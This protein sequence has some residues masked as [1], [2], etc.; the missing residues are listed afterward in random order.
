VSS[1]AFYQRLAAISDALSVGG[2]FVDLPTLLPASMVLELAGEGLRPRL[3]FATAP[4]GS[5]LCL[6][7]DLTIPAAVRYIEE[8]AT[9][10]A[11][12]AWACKGPVF[13]APRA[14]EDRPPEFVQI[15]LERFGDS[16]IVESDVTV[17]VAAWQACQGNQ[18]GVL[19]VRFCD[20]G[21]LPAILAQA[22]LGDVW[23]QALSEQTSHSRAFLRVLD[24]ASGKT[25]A[26]ALTALERDLLNL[27]LHEATA[28]VQKAIEE[29]DLS[30]A[31]TRSAQDVARHLVVRS[32]RA[33]APPLPDNIAET[34]ESLA[35]FE[36]NQSLGASLNA[37]VTLAAQ[38]E[39]DLSEWRA[40]WQARF[41]A[42][43]A[44]APD[45]LAHARFDALGEEAFDYYDGMAFDIG[46]DGDYQ[47]PLASGGRYDRLVGELSQGQRHAR[48]VGCVIRPDRFGD[49]L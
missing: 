18:I 34:L 39:V 4:D 27:P 2:N 23:H 47:R 1:E 19:S 49:A 48:A 42:I 25:P 10:N 45:A 29:G 36:H 8:A 26:R 5:E 13:R 32:S 37:I 24:M 6:R 40:A 17:F 14:G 11:P 33:S 28:A 35:R 30:L 3:F 16:D 15:G 38:M 20:G 46:V 9:D 21:L 31:A 43:G 7:P 12:V 22:D 41:T 44:V